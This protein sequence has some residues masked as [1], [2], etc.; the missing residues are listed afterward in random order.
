ML[1]VGGLVLGR[2]A[3]YGSWSVGLLSAGLGSLLVVAIHA[4]GG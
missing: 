1:Y 2:Y 4:L 3:G